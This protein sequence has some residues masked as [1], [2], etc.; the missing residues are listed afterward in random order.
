VQVLRQEPVFTYQIDNDEPIRQQI[1]KVRKTF[2]EKDKF[3]VVFSIHYKTSFGQTL[4][5][6]GSL[7]ELG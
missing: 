3:A 1:F 5:V 2:D 6:C 4:G 7:P